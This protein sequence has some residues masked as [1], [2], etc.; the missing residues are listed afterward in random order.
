MYIFNKPDIVQSTCRAQW[1]HH[2]DIFILRAQHSSQYIKG[3]ALRDSSRDFR[4]LF[5]D[6]L[7]IRRVNFNNL[8]CFAN[9]K[10]RS[11]SSSMPHSF[12]K[13]TLF[14]SYIYT[15]I[16][17]ILFPAFSESLY[18]FYLHVCV[19]SRKEPPLWGAGLGFEPEAASQQ[20]SALTSWLL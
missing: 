6:L 12:I 5:S 17:F 14:L 9:N 18:I 11:I 19:F 4:V 20:L 8:K 7:P 3:T 1:L 16:S 2:G 13:S 15:M 10:W